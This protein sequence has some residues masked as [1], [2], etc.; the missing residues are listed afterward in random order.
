VIRF[1]TAIAVLACLW[2]A[3][4]AAAATLQPIGDFAAPVYVTSDPGN[5]ERLFVVERTGKVLRLEGG[6]TSVFADLSS[7]V[8][9]EGSC[10]SNSER[11]LLSI[12][13]APD[14]DSSGR[15]YVDYANGND[16]VIH[17]SELR[18]VG[19]TSVP[20]SSLREVLAIP[21]PTEGN[22]NGCQLQ[23][24]PEGMLFVSTGDGGGENDVKHN[25]QNLETGLGKILRVNPDP[26]GPLIPAGNPFAGVAGDYAPIWSYGLRNPFRF[27]FDRLTGAIFIGDVGQDK[28]EE[29][30]YQG[31]PGLG[32][33]VN[34]GWN[35]MEGTITGP[36][37]D[38]GCPGVPSDFVAPI[39]DYTHEEGRCAIIG[40]YVVRDPG[41]TGLYGRYLYGD[42]C[43]GEI[44]SF[45]PSR[46]YETDRSEGLKVESV[47]SFGE[48]SCGRLYVVSNEGPVSRLVGPA[49]TDCSRPP[50]PTS[51]RA[52]SYVGI[53]AH[54]RRV[55]RNQR[56]L[57]TAWVS[58]CAGRKGEGV[59]LFEGARHLATRHL[60]R[61]CTVRFRPRIRH[62]ARFRAYVGEDTTYV[63]AIS[64]RLG[65]RID[66]RHRARRPGRP[67]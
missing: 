8:E 4:S 65:I 56:A 1:A 47:N 23:F 39:F 33:A 62:R 51:A 3:T 2:S 31:A 24:G 30:D 57:I 6:S 38:E 37:T 21:H 49:P 61:A 25:A 16:G 50:V 13:L 67:G 5:P 12:A 28:R 32:D 48:D 64:R 26:G 53:K 44:R 52:V 46:P 27:S 9:C 58:P 19:G 7:L 55:R 11:G 63:A 66:H 40:G 18:A 45:D 42:F 34:Y 54:G 20:L 22:H 10:L 60:D 14:F 15:L 17:V 36:G 41:L 59:K 29:V 35:C 43:S